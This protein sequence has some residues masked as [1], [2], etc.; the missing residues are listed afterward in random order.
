MVLPSAVLPEQ[1]T[2]AAAETELD[3]ARLEAL[4]LGRDAPPEAP[5]ARTEVDEPEPTPAPAPSAPGKPVTIAVGEVHEREVDTGAEP[6]AA[7]TPK[8]AGRVSKCV[9]R[10]D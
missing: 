2:D 8:P 7:P 5:R 3:P 9:G 10:A 4:M 1:P 6:P